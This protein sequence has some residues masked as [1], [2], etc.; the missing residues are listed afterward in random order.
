MVLC[1]ANAQAQSQYPLRQYLSIRASATPSLGASG[2]E[3]AFVTATTG[4][5]QVWKVST[6]GGWAD[7][8]TFF[9]SSV[10][11]VTWSPTDEQM[12][13]VADTDGNEQFQI[14]QVKA[15]GTGIT[16]LTNNPKGRHSFGGWSKNGSK[17]FYASNARDPRY[18]D[19]Y[20][21][22]MATHQS[23]VVFQ[24][25]SILEA[26]ALSADERWMIATEAVSNV[27][28]NL[29]LIDTTTGQGKIITSHTG[30]VT[31]EVIGFTADSKNL[32]LVTNQD[33]DFMNLAQIEIESGK[34]T[35]LKDEN[36]DL[37]GGALTPDGKTLAL[38]RNN[39]GYGELSLLD[40]KSLKPK[41]LP[42]LPKGSIGLGGFSADSRRLALSIN[43]PTKNT[44]VWIMDL[45]SR[46]LRQVTQS[47]RAGIDARTFQEP[48]LI[49]VKSFDGL[50]VPAFLYLP[51]NAP[52]NHSVP[53]ILSVHGGPEGQ[54]RPLFSSLYQYFVSRGFAVLAPNI[55]GSSGYG[56][57]Y[58]AMDNASLRWNALKDLAAL[59]DWVGTHPSLNSKK[60]AVMG[61]SY[62]GFAVL[63]MLVH[64]PEK[65]AA[66]VDMFGIADF[67]TFLANTAP[68]RRPLRIAE[69]GDPVRDSEFLDAISPARHV[70]RIQAPLMVIQGANDPRVPESESA[71]I[72]QKVKERGGK[73]EYL[74]FPDEGHGI[75]KLPNR[76]R[77]YEGLVSFLNKYMR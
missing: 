58:L 74:L 47:S 40:S 59:A 15:D 49:K 36:F 28:N 7:Q 31:Y 22:D 42:D 56:K 2:K 35:F 39:H 45:A 72:V 50:E 55:R 9:G 43:T 20:M 60:I 67:K 18:F 23:R 53:V 65:F 25:N 68:F 19:C 57:R 48:S 6:Q 1:S 71:L 13:V 54:E 64:Y 63:A 16:N 66:G 73:V 62:G 12:I 3:V 69:Y 77:A 51:A 24:K 70:D 21:M 10:Q 5:F 75:T 33:R 17:I 27:N 8:L 14:Y 38:L 32:L 30:D 34:L 26:V 61:G 41:R 46:K 44:D 52:Q 29:Y 76:I 11:S 4:T 37:F